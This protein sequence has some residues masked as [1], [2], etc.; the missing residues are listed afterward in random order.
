MYVCILFV[1]T[2]FTTPSC[3]SVCVCRNVCQHKWHSLVEYLPLSLS[4]SLSLFRAL[5]VSVTHLIRGWTK[6]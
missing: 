2:P 5:S 4:L 6:T 3:V 1:F